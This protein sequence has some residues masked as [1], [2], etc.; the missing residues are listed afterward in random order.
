MQLIHGDEEG[1]EAAG[2]QGGMREAR[3]PALLCRRGWRECFFPG[4]SGCLGPTAPAASGWARRTIPSGQ[5]VFRPTPVSYFWLVLNRGSSVRQNLFFVLLANRSGWT[6]KH[7]KSMT[8]PPCQRN[9]CPMD[10]CWGVPAAATKCCRAWPN[11]GHGVSP[12]EPNSPLSAH[13]ISRRWITDHLLLG[14]LLGIMY[15]LSPPEGRRVYQSLWIS[16]STWSLFRSHLHRMHWMAHPTQ[17]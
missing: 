14:D 15:V 8:A 16:C 3:T 13:A 6:A 4:W 9:G 11:S 1:T 17:T 10:E 7:E 2:V 12:M 5:E